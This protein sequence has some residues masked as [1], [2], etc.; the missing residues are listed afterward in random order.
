MNLEGGINFMA[1]IT[2]NAFQT[3]ELRAGDTVW[4]TFKATELI[5]TME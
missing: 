4:A 2:Q 1:E 5:T 3:L